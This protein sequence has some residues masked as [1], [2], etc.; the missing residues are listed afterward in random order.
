M[1]KLEHIATFRAEVGDG[2]D[3]GAGPA[4][5]R[6]IFDV[7]G[8]TFEGPR[9]KGK[10]LASGADWVVIG[11]DGVGRIDVRA[12]LQTDDGANIYVQYHGVLEL[13]EKVMGAVAAG[14]ETDF[15]DSYFFTA[16]RFETG[17]ERYAWLNKIVAIGQGRMIPNAVEYR[18]FEVQND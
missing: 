3:I 11:S 17:D 15:G 14:K 10:V 16:P 7:R 8:G 1:P 2:V 6:Q 5:A 13:N 4:G 12:T 9:M 18:I